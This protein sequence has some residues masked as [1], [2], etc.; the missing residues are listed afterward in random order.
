MW[1]ASLSLAGFCLLGLVCV[2]RGHEQVLLS[3]SQINL[4][5]HFS[6]IGDLSVLVESHYAELSHPAFPKYNVR[7]K[8][9][10]FCDGT[11]KWVSVIAPLSTLN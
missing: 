4:E 11:V 5:T 1:G 7:I 3:K 8:K 2:A 9:S 6:P 10:D